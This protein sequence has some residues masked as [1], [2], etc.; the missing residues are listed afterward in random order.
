MNVVFTSKDYYHNSL[1]DI[2][3]VVILVPSGISKFSFKVVDNGSRL[4][5]TATWPAVLRN[6]RSLHRKWI[7]AQNN[8]AIRDYHPRV[9][10]YQEAVNCIKEEIGDNMESS[11]YI[12]LPIVVLSEIRSSHFLGFETCGSRIYYIDLTAST[13]NQEVVAVD[14]SPDLC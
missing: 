13:N 2:V 4:Q 12:S 1:V 6:A 9:I 5:F 10:G 3:S 8:S 14:E 7:N 11:A